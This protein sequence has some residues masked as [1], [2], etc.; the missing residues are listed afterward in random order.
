MFKKTI[1]YRDFLDNEQVKDFYFHLSKAEL[2]AMAADGNEFQAR[3]KRITE[4]NDGASILHEFRQ[5]IKL[6]VGVRTEDGARFVKDAEAQSNLL[7]SPAFDELLMEL[8]TN[9]EAASDF[10]SKLI[11]EH[12]QKEMVEQLK[13]NSEAPDGP[14]EVADGRPLYQRE[15][16]KPTPKE[17]Q[18]MSRPE[19][20]EAMAWQQSTPEL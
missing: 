16:R 9:A 7:D 6:A 17:L 3:I 18:A 14:G 12:L 2:L 19:L 5:I 13:I 4:A 1:K 8:A 20:I 11:P 10:I 15:N